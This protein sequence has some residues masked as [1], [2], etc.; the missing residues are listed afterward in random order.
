MSEPKKA[1]KASTK[2]QA[3]KAS[4]KQ[5]RAN[6]SPLRRRDSSTKGAT[7]T[8]SKT[9]KEKP[10]AGGDVPNGEPS[11]A[12]A[13]KRSN[14][15]NRNNSNSNCDVKQKQVGSAKQRKKDKKNV[16]N[17]KNTELA[18]G[19]NSNKAEKKD[20]KCNNN[21]G[22]EKEKEKSKKNKSKEKPTTPKGKGK[23]KDGAMRKSRSGYVFRLKNKT[24]TTALP[25][26]WDMFV[27]KQFT[28]ILHF[29][30]MFLAA[31]V[32]QK[33]ASQ[34]KH[35]I[36]K[37]GVKIFLLIDDGEF[38]E[39]DFDK[40][41]SLFRR[42]CS[43]TKNTYLTRNSV[44][45]PSNTGKVDKSQDLPQ[46]EDTVV[47]KLQTHMTTL[48]EGIVELLNPYLSKQ[49]LDM[50]DE[51]YQVC[52]DEEF[53]VSAFDDPCMPKVVCVFAEFLT[54]Y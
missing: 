1:T 10:S 37:T 2:K 41:Y 20:N 6:S 14:T 27:D 32:G 35:L 33:K 21:K 5:K 31:R 40:S 22:K 17:N 46:I 29:F 11:S 51:L 47:E 42:I 25:V 38:G 39:H 45:L 18:N 12:R 28:E 52:V 24:A 53:I 23:E 36:M 7:K 9:T 13:K 16:N 4:E 44:L 43:L 30:K 3:T 26:L 19:N 8:R 49:K 50:I 54:N 34:F 15:K 48:K